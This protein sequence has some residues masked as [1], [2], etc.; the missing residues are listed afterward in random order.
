MTAPISALISTII[1]VYN[2]E[3]YLADTLVSA[4]AQDY[5]RQEIIVVD[6]GSTDSTAAIVQAYPTLRY[7]FQTNQGHGAAKNTGIAAAQGDFLAFLDADDVWL[8]DKL[9]IQMRHLLAHSKA[10]IAICLMET[11]LEEDM[12]WPANLNKAHYRQTPPAYLPS[13]LLAHR[14]V[15]DQIGWFAPQYYH[16]NDSDWFFRAQDAG[17]TIAIVPQ[18][19]LRH[20][21]HHNNLS[22]QAHAI[23]AELL[24]VIRASVQ[25][26]RG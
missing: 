18:V 14:R 10:E 8:P 6:D 12:E 13:A 23:N 16:S 26:K 20:R 5:G 2:G 1:P 17:L 9:S 24:G 21:L 3:R 7:V 25:R 19:L 11:L 22:Y 4:L 15:F